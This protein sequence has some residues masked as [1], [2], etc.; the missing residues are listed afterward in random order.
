MP[1]R[2]FPR[3]AQ[4]LWC[5]E[6]K[7]RHSMD[8]G[9]GGGSVRYR[10]EFGSDSDGRATARGSVAA[11]LSL[12]CQRCF[13][14]YELA[15]DADVSLALVSGLDEANA[16]PSQ[17]EPWLVEDRLM[18]PADLIEDELVLAVPAIPRHQEGEC[19]PPG[20]LAKDAQAPIEQI[21]ASPVAA[22]SRHPFAGL[23][24]LKTTRDDPERQ[25]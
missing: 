15:V 23:A 1:L 14:R 5:A 8:E 7:E 25:D 10:F 22:A 13:E 16:L 11:S 6:G 3:L 18:R 19:Q 2:R 9:P 20:S 12:R 21:K 17:Y 24:V 4:L